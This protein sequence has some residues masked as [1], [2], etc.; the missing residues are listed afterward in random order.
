VIPTTLAAGLVAAL[1]I[2]PALGG[3]NFITKKKVVK[4][5]AKKSNA[6]QVVSSQQA[7]VPAGAE[8]LLLTL[9]LSKPGDYLVRSTFS[10]IRD[11]QGYVT[12][13]LR[14]GGVAADTASSAADGPPATQE[15][16]AVAM[17]TAGQITGPTQVTLTCQSALPGTSVR[18]V[19]ITA[20]RVPRLTVS[21]S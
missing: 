15:E 5:I 11:T 2:S 18:Y 7:A 14:I 1:L 16:E 6:I 19:E 20:E 21:G 10:V 9:D 12:C 8:R 13:R 3:P 4:T 17:E